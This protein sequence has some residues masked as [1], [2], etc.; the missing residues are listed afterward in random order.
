MKRIG[1]IGSVNR[2]TIT[3]AEG[4][5]ARDLGGILYTSLAL[6]YLGGGRIETWLLCKLGADV[7]EE[8]M[9]ILAAAPALRIDGVKI[10]PEANF[11]SRIRYYPDGG[12]DERLS[13]EIGPLGQE[14]LDPFISNLDGLL[15]NFITGFELE[16]TTLQVLRQRLPGL[17]LM[18]VHSL[19]LGRTRS[20][21]RFWKQPENW[22]TWL[23]QADIVQM[24]EAEAVLL[25][26]LSEPGDALLQEFALRLL[27]LGPQGVVVTRGEKGALGAF[28][29]AGGRVCQQ[30]AE[31]PDLADDPTG[32]GDVFLAAM[33]MG[34]FTGR[35][36]PGAMEMACR[37]ASLTSR[38]QGVGNLCRLAGLQ[39]F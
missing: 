4:Q 11:H 24:N 20:G 30:P 27:E 2:D 29:E 38:F 23:A 34:I 25:G 7:A 32:C 3:S 15:V 10:V 31:Q 37:A 18:D 9:P 26:E 28:R 5:V 33:G 12:K 17:L 39:F 8:V 22:Q 21:A 36:L 14:D 6:A 19:T 1:V 13:G 16:L 35:S